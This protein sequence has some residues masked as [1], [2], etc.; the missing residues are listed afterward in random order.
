M[1][2]EQNERLE[3]ELAVAR[4]DLKTRDRELQLVQKELDKQRETTTTFNTKLNRKATAL[5]VMEGQG[6][7]FEFQTQKTISPKEQRSENAALRRQIT[8]SLKEVE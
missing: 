3:T 8:A 2:T 4:E 6:I 5:A 1:L 7:N